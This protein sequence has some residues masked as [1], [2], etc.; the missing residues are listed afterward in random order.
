MVTVEADVDRVEC[1]LAAGELSCPSCGGVLDGVIGVMESRISAAAFELVERT[2]VGADVRDGLPR[3][4]QRA[5]ALARAALLSPPI[6]AGIRNQFSELDHGGPAWFIDLCSSAQRSSR[7]P[8]QVGGRSQ[9]G[10]PQIAGCDGARPRRPAR[11][12]R[13]RRA[14]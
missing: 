4:V 7:R 5:Q 3:R 2:D 14:R 12:G 9:R 8:H 10:R 11:P 1:R 6:A 13:R